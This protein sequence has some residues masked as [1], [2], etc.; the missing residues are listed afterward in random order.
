MSKLWIGCAVVMVA[1]M[2][3]AQ[4]TPLCHAGGRQWGVAVD[5]EIDYG[6]ARTTVV[7]DL[8]A[9]IYEKIEIIDYDPTGAPDPFVVNLNPDANEATWQLNLVSQR[10]ENCCHQLLMQ[11]TTTMTFDFQTPDDQP[12]REV[13]L[14]AGTAEEPVESFI[15]AQAAGCGTP[16]GRYT[17]LRRWA[18]IH[19]IFATGL[20]PQYITGG[21][22][23]YRNT[24]GQRSKSVV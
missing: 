8:E 6:W 19:C 3:W 7:H 2:A 16:S 20:P 23:V 5:E 10:H 14:W 18:V 11:G 13:W 15:E 21:E 4:Q 24:L 9:S 1:G 17:W 12:D 22:Q